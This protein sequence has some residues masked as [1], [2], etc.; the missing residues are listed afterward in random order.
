MADENDGYTFRPVAYP[1]RR[2]ATWNVSRT[3]HDDV[4]AEAATHKWGVNELRVPRPGFWDILREQLV[5]PFFA[6]QTFCCVLWL[7]DE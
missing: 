4:S 6:F 1:D 2:F 3:G 5:A 7:A